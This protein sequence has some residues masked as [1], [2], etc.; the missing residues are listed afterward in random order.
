MRFPVLPD[1]QFVIVHRATATP[2]R[3]LRV[4]HGA[5]DLLDALRD[6]FGDA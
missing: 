5:R 2:P 3:I 1:F 6:I 4:L